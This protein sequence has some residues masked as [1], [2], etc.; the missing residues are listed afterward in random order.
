MRCLPPPPPLA[1][2]RR[3]ANKNKMNPGG[4]DGAASLCPPHPGFVYGLCFLCGAKEEEEDAAEEVAA[5]GP[6]A[7]RLRRRR[8]SRA[9]PTSGPSRARGS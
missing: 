9:R 4:I 3:R 7:A 5:A 8:A 6:G 2:R 1:R